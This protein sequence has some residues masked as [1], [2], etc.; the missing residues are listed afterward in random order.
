MSRTGPR[1]AKAIC[2]TP[3]SRVTGPKVLITL[4]FGI[5]VTSGRTYGYF[6]FWINCAFYLKFTLLF[7]SGDIKI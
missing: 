5:V 2:F 1:G 3:Y 7:W 4:T 6:C